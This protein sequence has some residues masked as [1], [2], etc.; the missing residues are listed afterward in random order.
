[1]VRSGVRV[2]LGLKVMTVLAA[3]H[4]AVMAS[5]QLKGTWNAQA[6]PPPPPTG[7]EAMWRRAK[8]SHLPTHKLT[9]LFLTAPSQ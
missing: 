6:P 8:P 4:L 1:M 3:V 5:S 9:P 2:W 7:Q